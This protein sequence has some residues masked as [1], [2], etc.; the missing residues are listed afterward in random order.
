MT[1]NA[2][3]Q[4]GLEHITSGIGRSSTYVFE[5]GKG[6]YVTTDEGVKLLDFTSYVTP[7]TQ[8]HRRR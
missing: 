2:E 6:S 8:G 3:A 1:T 4:F 5:E 7:L